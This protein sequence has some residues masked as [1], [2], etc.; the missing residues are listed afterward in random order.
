M[1]VCAAHGTDRHRTGALGLGED[2]KEKRFQREGASRGMEEKRGEVNR[3]CWEKKYEL[4]GASHLV[5]LGR[6]PPLEEV[7]VR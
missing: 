1:V 5:R 4:N 7:K 6:G 2:T 3:I